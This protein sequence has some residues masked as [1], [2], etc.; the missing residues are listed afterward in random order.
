MKN[1]KIN[2]LLVEDDRG[3]AFY[4]QE[5]LSEQKD[6]LIETVWVETIGQAWD[7]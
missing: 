7:G 1:N 2:V 4:V 5:I 6:Q 3:D